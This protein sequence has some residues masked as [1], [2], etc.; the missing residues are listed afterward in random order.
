MGARVVEVTLQGRTFALRTDADPGTLERAVELA[1]SRLDELAAA[2]APHTAALL[3]VLSLS[4]ELVIERE[5]MTAVREQIRSKSS[6]LLE[7]L[8]GAG[9]VDA[10]GVR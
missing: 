6:S 4:E 10:P 1:N 2:G 8:D 3:A 5:A 9:P 7:M